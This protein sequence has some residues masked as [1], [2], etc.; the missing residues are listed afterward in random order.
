MEQE[1]KDLTPTITEYGI[2]I[3]LKPYNHI[4]TSGKQVCEKDHSSP[5]Y[6]RSSNLKITPDAVWGGS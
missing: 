2:C 5:P 1:S 3:T 4:K 6:I